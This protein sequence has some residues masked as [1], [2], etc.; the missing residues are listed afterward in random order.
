M[1]SFVEKA[2]EGSGVVDESEDDAEIAL[3]ASPTIGGGDCIRSL[4]SS[5]L[6]VVFLAAS[7]CNTAESKGTLS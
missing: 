7:C 2:M 1:N 3:V 4:F 5:C 6:G